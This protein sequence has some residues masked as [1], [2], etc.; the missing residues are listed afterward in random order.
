LG[1]RCRYWRGDER[2][3]VAAKPVR[4]SRAL[5]DLAGLVAA[6]QQQGWA[7]V[8]LDC[9]LEPT[10]PAGEET[11]TVLAAFAPLERGLISTR[12]RERSRAS[13]PRAPGSAAPQRCPGT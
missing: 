11:A 5:L 4:L 3:L 13:A 9:A 2:T 10:T 6:A 1:G 8:A 12:T 7:L